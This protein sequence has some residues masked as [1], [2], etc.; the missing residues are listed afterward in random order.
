MQPRGRE[1]AVEAWVAVEPLAQP[2]RRLRPRRSPR[3]VG[4][5]D[6]FAV[7]EHAIE[8]AFDSRRP[9]MVL[10]VGEAGV[11]KSRLAEW[12]C[13]QVHEQG[14]MIPLRA[15][16]GRIPTPLDGIND[17]T[18]S[19]TL[20]YLRAAQAVSAQRDG[21]VVRYQL[22]STPIKALLSGAAW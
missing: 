15:R 20:R 12:L 5:D 1:G 17:V 2:G 19:Q 16:Y 13:E 22:A 14:K 7:L 21:R 10:L 8:G 9:T 4:R 3:L 11:G 18:V 6:E